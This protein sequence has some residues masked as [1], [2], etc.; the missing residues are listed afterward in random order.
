MVYDI[1]PIG[2]GDQPEVDRPSVK[3][4]TTN[5]DIELRIRSL[6]SNPD[7]E[8][9]SD[10]IEIITEAYQGGLIPKRDYTAYLDQ[11]LD[12]RERGLTRCD[13]ERPLD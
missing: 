2:S 12:M 3:R 4:L 5:Q 9:I 13:V 7:I 8:G 11:L 1:I 10:Q 6:R